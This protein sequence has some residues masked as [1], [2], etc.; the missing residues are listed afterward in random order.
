VQPTDVTKR[1][2]EIEKVIQAVA[3]WHV[4]IVFLLFPVPAE[5]ELHAHNSNVRKT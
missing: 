5:V 4:N 1:S 2:E 3:V